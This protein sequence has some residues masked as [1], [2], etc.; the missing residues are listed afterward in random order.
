V[1][2]SKSKKAELFVGALIVAEVG[3]ISVMFLVDPGEGVKV[4]IAPTEWALPILKIQTVKSP[5]GSPTIELIARA[6]SEKVAIPV[7]L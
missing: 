3:D 6:R 1:A 4:D 5:P 7:A 2:S